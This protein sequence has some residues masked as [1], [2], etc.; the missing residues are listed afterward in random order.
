MLR[1][2]QAMVAV[3]GQIECTQQLRRCPHDVRAPLLLHVLGDR[4]LGHDVAQQQANTVPVFE[5]LSIDLTGDRTDE[6]S[7]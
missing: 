3:F 7:R 2:C 6:L 5:P 4:S 1:K